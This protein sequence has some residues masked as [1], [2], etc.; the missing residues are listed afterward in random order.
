M[1]SRG[2][3]MGREVEKELGGKEVVGVCLRF[4]AYGHCLPYLHS[5]LSGRSLKNE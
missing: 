4:P 5:S 3:E 2:L 1:F